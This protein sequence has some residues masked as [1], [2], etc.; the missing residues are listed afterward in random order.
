M[1]SFVPFYA[2]WMLFLLSLVFV[3]SGN[4]LWAVVRESDLPHPAAPY[5][6][7]A[8]TPPP[9][10]TLE[11]QANQ[12][13]SAEPSALGVLELN[14]PNLIK[15]SIVE[16]IE[17]KS[18]LLKV[19][20]YPIDLPLVLK[21][22]ET[23]NLSIAESQKNTEIL[24]SRLRQAQVSILPNIEGVY[25]QSRLQGA[26]QI[27]GGQVVEVVRDTVQPQIAANWTVYPGGRTIYQMLAA[28]RRKTASDFTL[29]ETRQEQLSGAAQD[30]YKLLVA[31]M[32]KGVIVRNLEE[33]VEQV[34][35]NQLKAK[36]GQGIPLDLSRAKTNFAQQ[37][38]ALIQ[39]DTAIVQAE[40]TLLNRLNLDPTIHLVPNEMDALKKPLVSA[41]MPF[42]QLLSDAMLQNPSLKVTDEELKALNYDYKTV[43]SDLIPSLTLRTY[44]NKTGPDWENLANTKFMGVTVNM[45]LLQNMGFQI[46]LQMQERKKLVEQKLIQRQALVRAIE[47]QV[48]V[49]YLNSQN[50]ESAIASAEQEVTSATESYQLAVGRFTAGYG[51]NLDVLNAQTALAVARNNLVLAILNYNQA[52]V[53][54]VEALG[55]STPDVLVNG[56][57]RQGNPNNGQSTGQKQKS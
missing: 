24:Q 15:E 26:Q 10:A 55:Q 53:R 37:Q 48:T 52:Q 36:V 57:Q 42:K 32:Q 41:E 50:Y 6:M 33:A 17:L 3:G 7:M 47:N 51:I 54:L 23:Q 13:V 34:R 27:F 1:R 35:L 38:T 20:N 11:I 49:A 8:V 2:S 30:Y 22:I 45:N 39:A 19:E 44:K 12:T 14:S 21:L 31:Y 16:P 18:H 40:Q 25:T 9:A 56:L 43:R 28:K 46:P 29:Q 4:P 5:P